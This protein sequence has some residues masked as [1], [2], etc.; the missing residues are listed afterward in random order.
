VIVNGTVMIDG[1]EHFGA[2]PGRLLTQHRTL[3]YPVATS[4]LGQTLQVAFGDAS[5]EVRSN[6]KADLMPMP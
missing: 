1:G 5:C 6:P 3:P 2:L 4:Q